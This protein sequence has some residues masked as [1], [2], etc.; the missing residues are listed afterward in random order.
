[1]NTKREFK[2]PS[3]EDLDKE[4]D[5][6]LRL[7]EDGIFLVTGGPG[8]G[9]S[10]VSLIRRNRVKKSKNYIFLVYNH[11]LMR[12]TK[13]MVEGEMNGNTWNK[14]FNDE[15]KNLTGNRPE[16]K[17]NSNDIDF[18]DTILKLQAH[19]EDLEIPVND[20]NFIIDEGQDMPPEFY[21]SLQEMGFINFFV[22]ADQN[23]QIT[24]Q[25]S[26]ILQLENTLA[27]EKKYE[28]IENYR[29]SFEIA[30]FARQ[31]YDDPAT[32]PPKLPSPE[33]QN[34]TPIKIHEYE[35][36]SEEFELLMKRILAKYSRNP[37]N[38]IG[39]FTL[40]NV[41]RNKYINTLNTVKNTMGHG[42]SKVIISTY[43]WGDSSE[44][45][46]FTRGGIV[47]LNSASV[48]GLEFD[49]VFIADID[50]F[51]KKPQVD[52]LKK[53][54]YVMTS[55]ARNHLALLRNKSHKRQTK[56]D[57]ILPLD[58]GVLLPESQKPIKILVG[59]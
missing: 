45:I 4:Q 6:I 37:K 3:V 53:I 17:S 34:P 43:S 39:I 12:S 11:V 46:D 14:W 44:N 42:M 36:T 22:V 58:K 10:V 52:E 26:S 31:F 1:M 24:S 41:T 28:L 33:P 20:L 38:L 5:V 56:L 19:F 48:K 16:R 21:E 30:F 50:E 57:S 55:R 51:N 23:Q 49:Q 59:A 7:P 8:T 25:K 47:V 13:Q 32:L 27:P 54:F 18:D 9:K 35:D 29:N 15:F 40:S 2:L